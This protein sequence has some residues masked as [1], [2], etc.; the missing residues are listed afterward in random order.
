MKVIYT[1]YFYNWIVKIKD[2]N[3]RRQIIKKLEKIE[4]EGFFGDC[5]NLGDGIFEIRIF[6]GSGYRIYFSKYDNRIIVCLVGGDKSNQQK[7]IERAKKYWQE[8]LKEE[9]NK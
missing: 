8:F 4:I 5:K 6:L 2:F 7:D 9:L 3:L 1:K